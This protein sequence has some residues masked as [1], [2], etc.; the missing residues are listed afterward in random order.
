MTDHRAQADRIR[1]KLDQARK[2]DPEFREYGARI[3]RYE[4][5]PP[6]TERDVAEFEEANGVSL[7]GCYRAFLTQVG[8]GSPVAGHVLVSPEGI[9][10]LTEEEIAAYERNHRVSVDPADR[11][12]LARVRN[13][14]PVDE[15]YGAGPGHGLIPLGRSTCFDSRHGMLLDVGL[16]ADSFSST[17]VVAG[18]LAGRVL[19]RDGEGVK[20]ARFYRSASFLDWYEGWLDEILPE[21]PIP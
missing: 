10:P 2:V 1:R 4:L 5:G 21:P 3:H 20:E 19:R 8:N 9:Y 14:I 7:P 17:I 18:P 12:Y 16:Q 6:L 13:A 15:G 11:A